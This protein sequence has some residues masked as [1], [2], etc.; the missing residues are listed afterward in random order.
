MADPEYRK[1]MVDDVAASGVYIDPTLV[2]YYSVFS[3]VDDFLYAILPTDENLV[4]LP[5]ETRDKYLNPETN[6]YRTDEFP[7]SAKHLESNIEILKTLMFELHEAGVPLLLGTDS[8]GTLIPGF[9]VHKELELTVE[10]G[11]SPYEALGTGTVNVAS[12]LGKKKTEGTIVVGKRADFI[13]LEENPLKDISHTRNVKGVFTQVNWY[14]DLELEK[15][16]EEARMISNS[17]E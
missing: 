14:S 11:L 12:Y 5:E 15:M 9:S 16:L 4:Y 3:W 2:I 8:F 17:S 7:F 13:I 1:P 10:A 6:P